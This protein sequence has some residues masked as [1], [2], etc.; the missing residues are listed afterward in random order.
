LINQNTDNVSDH[1]ML[2]C[3]QSNKDSIVL[4]QSL[5]VYKSLRD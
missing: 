1:N 5:T 2:R 4:P 3:L